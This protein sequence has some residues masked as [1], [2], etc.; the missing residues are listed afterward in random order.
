MEQ[1]NSGAEKNKECKPNL[2]YLKELSGGDTNFITEII[3]MFM[4][5]APKIIEQA[6]RC[7][8]EENYDLLKVTVHKLK[9]S[10]QVLGGSKL[11]LSIQEIESS[12][13][14]PD[15]K[16]ELSDMLAQVENSIAQMISSLNS[17]L[18]SMRNEISRN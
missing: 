15:K 10:V 1:S 8:R 18:E 9:S 11:A 5:D 7:F 12:A 17:E 14:N 3:E 13:K 2:S 4:S 16:D 6:N